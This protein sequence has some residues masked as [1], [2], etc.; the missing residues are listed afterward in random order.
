[1]S[2]LDLYKQMHEKGHFPGNST[3]KN[4]AMIGELVKKH[5]ARHILDYGSGKGAQYSELKLHEAWGVTVGCY[6]PAVPELS[7][8]PHPMT[9]FDGV[10]CCDVLEHLEGRDLD[11]A[12][13]NV[14]VRAA[15]FCFFS[16]ATFPA[17]KL[18]PDGRNAHLT[19]ESKDWWRAKIDTAKFPW[20]G[21]LV[22]HFDEG[23]Q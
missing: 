7:K 2:N 12:I 17:K 15:K 16:V 20:C 21:E 19:L 4:A 5:G 11:V 22:V 3:A 8:L 14:T 6:D 10:I 23:D 9:L 13:F 1:V 18:L